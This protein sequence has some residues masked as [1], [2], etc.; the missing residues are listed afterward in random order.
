MYCLKIDIPEETCTIDDVLEG[1]YH[2]IDA[3]CR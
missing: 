2:S 3:L 1:I